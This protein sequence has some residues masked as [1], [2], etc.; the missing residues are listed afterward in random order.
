MRIVGKIVSC[1]LYA[2]V[3][4]L[5][6]AF[7]FIEGR[8]LF[9]LD[10]SIYDSAWNGLIHYAMRLILALFA[11]FVCVAEFVNMKRKSGA[12]SLYLLFANVALVAVA[13]IVFALATNYANVVIPI[14][15]ALI[16]ARSCVLFFL[17]LH[18]G[19]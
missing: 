2:I 9:S 17:Y 6:L 12:W 10:W 14:L 5:A 4:I 19:V 1:L 13:V 16:L 15:G 7:I 11:L 8:L 3:A 18:R